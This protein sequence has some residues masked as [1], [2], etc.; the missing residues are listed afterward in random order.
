[1]FLIFRFSALFAFSVVQSPAFA[2]FGLNRKE[3]REHKE[4][5]VNAAGGGHQVVRRGNGGDRIY[6]D[7]TGR[8]WKDMTAINGDPGW[9]ALQ[10]PLAMDRI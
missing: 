10:K 9:N 1:M 8:R 6:R 7:D 5:R 3:R 2:V 4:G